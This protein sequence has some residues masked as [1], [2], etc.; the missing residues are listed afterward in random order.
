MKLS[1]LFMWL[2]YNSPRYTYMLLQ[3]NNPTSESFPS[4]EMATVT[5]SASC[6][7]RH[8]L[9]S[10]LYVTVILHKSWTMSLKLWVRDGASQ[11]SPKQWIDSNTP[12]AG[13]MSTS[14]EL[15]KNITPFNGCDTIPSC[16]GT[17]TAMAMT[18]GGTD[19]GSELR[20]RAQ[21]QS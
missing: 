2:C 11:T 18:A 16:A 12:R 20:L 19:R 1:F 14:A 15:F 3:N 9:Y 8:L 5:P 13:H 21:K 4:P 6:L 10:I 7:N 17:V